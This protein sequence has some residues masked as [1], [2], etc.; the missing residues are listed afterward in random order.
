MTIP[1]AAETTEGITSRPEV[2]SGEEIGGLDGSTPNEIGR[3]V[4]G[5]LGK[6][7]GFRWGFV[8]SPQSFRQSPVSETLFVSHRTTS[9]DYRGRQN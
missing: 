8:D 6:L 7:G 4:R 3:R 1:I 5:T 9:S 2:L